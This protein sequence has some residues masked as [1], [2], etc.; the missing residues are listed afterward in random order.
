MQTILNSCDLSSPALLWPCASH[1]LSWQ[2]PVACMLTRWKGC[3]HKALLA[4]RRRIPWHACSMLHALMPLG[5]ADTRR[6]ALAVEVLRRS[7]NQ[8]SNLPKI[9][10]AF[11]QAR[12]SV[13]GLKAWFVPRAAIFQVRPRR[14]H[15]P[16][17][18]L[19]SSS[20]SNTAKPNAAASCGSLWWLFLSSS[21]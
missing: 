4:C 11:H 20:G 5:G 15:M 13:P 7:A 8:T 1:C 21:I 3:R 12:L 17:L 19:M 16:C 10:S 2:H 9:G 14:P 6:E 18:Q